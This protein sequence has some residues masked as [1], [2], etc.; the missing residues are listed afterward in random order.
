[1]DFQT[2]KRVCEEV[3]IIP[4]KALKNKIAGYTTVRPHPPARSPASVTA[5]HPLT[6]GVHTAAS[7]CRPPPPPP[8]PG[9]GRVRCLMPAPMPDALLPPLST[10]A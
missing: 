1:M 8:Q 4:S 3:A 2:N 10:I 5:A 7:C 9:A 6:G